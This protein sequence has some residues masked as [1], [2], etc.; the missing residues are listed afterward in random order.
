MRIGVF[1]GSF[2]PIHYGHLRM[3]VEAQEQARLDRVI[4]VPNQV[5]PF[6]VG[7]TET[8]GEI[9]AEMVRWAIVDNPRFV[10]SRVEVERPGPS[11]TVDT[12]RAIQQ[13]VGAEHELFLL[14]GSDTLQGFPGWRDPEAI[15]QMARF[16]VV[17][18][19]GASWEDA[20][21]ALPPA[22]HER[23]GWVEMPLTGVSSTDI[24]ERCQTRKSVNYL[25]PPV[26][27]QCIFQHNL[28][29]GLPPRKA[30]AVL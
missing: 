8:P 11:F 9:R 10:L 21:A 20:L 12:L 16:L 23:I 25:V 27:V 26:V 4:F 7:Q 18:R 6:K 24:R 15:L 1:G 17:V 22:W 3:A 13:E 19:P 28:Y 2:D 30:D 29:Y 5:S 14:V